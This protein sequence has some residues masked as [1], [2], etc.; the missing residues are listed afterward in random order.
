MQKK[1]MEARSSHVA[2][3]CQGQCTWTF[4]EIALS[5]AACM[6]ICKDCEAWEE[7]QLQRLLCELYSLQP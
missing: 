4:P 1:L 7:L 5:C 2:G 6:C 3:A